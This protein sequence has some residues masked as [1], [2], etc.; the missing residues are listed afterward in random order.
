MRDAVTDLLLGGRC[1]GCGVAGR[2]LCAGLRGRLCPT[3]AHPA[4]PDRTPAGLVPPWAAAA[5]DGAA[6]AMVL[7]LQGAPPAGSGPA[8]SRACSPRRSRRCSAPPGPVV[9]VPRA[10][11]AREACAP[12][13]TT[14]RTP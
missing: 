8:R 12:A 14:R 9:L 10:V 2:L 4:W 7:G 6:R 3:G 11:A 1:V 5:Y 13:A